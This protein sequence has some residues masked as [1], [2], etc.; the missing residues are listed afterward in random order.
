MNIRRLAVR[1]HLLELLRRLRR[2]PPDGFRVSTLASICQMDP[3]STSFRDPIWIADWPS[4]AEGGMLGLVV[5]AWICSNALF[6]AT[7]I[8]RIRRSALHQRLYRSNDILRRHVSK[9]RGEGGLSLFRYTKPSTFFLRV[10][11]L[12]TGRAYCSPSV[13][14]VRAQCWRPTISLYNEGICPFR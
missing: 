6:P 7:G 9:W 3:P 8:D 1:E 4:V 11:G 12:V 14:G 5:V 2:P 13:P 10:I